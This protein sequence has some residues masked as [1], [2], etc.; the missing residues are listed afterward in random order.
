M[1]VVVNFMPQPLNPQRKNPWYPLD[2][3]LDTVRE[4]KNFLH[5]LQRIPDSLSIHPETI[6][7][8]LSWLHIFC[9]FF[10]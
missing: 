5:K 7:V 4:K 8:E 2:R 3:R 9:T 6:P 1:Q 10:V